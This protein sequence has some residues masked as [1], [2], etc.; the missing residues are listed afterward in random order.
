MS[1]DNVQLPLLWHPLVRTI[2]VL[3]R[4]VILRCEK[5]LRKETR[6]KLGLF[7]SFLRSLKPLGL[8]ITTVVMRTSI[9]TGN[10]FMSH[11]RLNYSIPRTRFQGSRI[12]TSLR[13]ST[14]WILRQHTNRILLSIV[15]SN[16]SLGE[17]K[18]PFC[19][20]DSPVRKWSSDRN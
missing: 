11:A 7:L 16:N 9:L 18:D 4:F 12:F 17:G 20:I 10:L 1:G 6:F 5:C 14:L 2:E 15:I 8:W 13:R 3:E 19:V